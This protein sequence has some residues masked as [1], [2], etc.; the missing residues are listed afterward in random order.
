M[1]LQGRSQASIEQDQSAHRVLAG[2]GKNGMAGYAGNPIFL[3]IRGLVP[4]ISP[5]VV[6]GPG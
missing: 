1:R 4:A 5:E 3:L 6:Y 2:L